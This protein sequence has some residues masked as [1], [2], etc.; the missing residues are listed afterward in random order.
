M[1]TVRAGRW[2]DG[3]DPQGKK[4]F[5]S[6]GRTKDSWW[7]GPVLALLATGSFGRESWPCALDETVLS[8][9]RK[10]RLHDGLPHIRVSLLWQLLWYRSASTVRI[11]SINLKESEV[12]LMLGLG[13]PITSSSSSCSMVAAASSLSPT[14]QCLL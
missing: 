8:H 2:Q 4:L 9:I 3:P 12:S 6:F 14:L 1:V 10:L 5:T 11:V 13:I 7:S